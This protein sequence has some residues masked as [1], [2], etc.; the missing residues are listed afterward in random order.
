MLFFLC[1]LHRL[2]RPGSS[3]AVTGHRAL[4][5]LL[6]GNVKEPPCLMEPLV[7]LRIRRVGDVSE[8]TSGGYHVVGRV[9]EAQRAGHPRA[10]VVVAKS[11]L[12]LLHLLPRPL[13]LGFGGVEIHLPGLEARILLLEVGRVA[14]GAQIRR[15]EVRSIGGGS[16]VVDEKALAGGR[17]VVDVVGVVL[18]AIPR[19]NLKEVVQ[20]GESVPA[21]PERM[22]P[23]GASRQTRCSNLSWN[24]SAAFWIP[25][26]RSRR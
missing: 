25:Y 5:L 18:Q 26:R 20:R 10:V 9:G 16:P 19:E 22:T 2:G 8:A 24:V 14:G 3:G 1:L 23:R 4:R 12:L 17:E 13:E 15:C 11:G 6:E 21:A 7:V